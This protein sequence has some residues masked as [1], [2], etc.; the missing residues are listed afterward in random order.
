MTITFENDNDVIIYA[1][2]KVI[3]YTRRTQEIFVAQC[4]WW[5]VSIIGLEQGLIHYIDNLQSQKEEG[6]RL[7]SNSPKDSDPDYTAARVHPSRTHQGIS[8]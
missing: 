7:L 6:I 3:A 8:Q 4:V 2:E 5:L 1:L